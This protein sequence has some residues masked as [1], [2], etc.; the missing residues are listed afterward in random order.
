MG[1]DPER[2][3]SHSGR[4]CPKRVKADA[5]RHASEG[6]PSREVNRLAQ[7]DRFGLMAVTGRQVWLYREYVYL[8]LAEA[9]V[10]AYNT[11]QASASWPEWARENVQAA[12]LL[13][14]AERLSQELENA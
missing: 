9:V 7:I 13:T 6:R 2:V 14:E 11:R 1:R 12:A 8:L 5:Y 3:Q 10:N 4:A